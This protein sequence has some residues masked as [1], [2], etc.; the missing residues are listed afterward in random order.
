MFIDS[1][2]LEDELLKNIIGALF[3]CLKMT[4][5]ENEN[6]DKQNEKEEVIIFHLTKI[7]TLTLLNIENIFILFDDYLIPIINSLIEKKI[8]LNFTVNLVCSIIKEILINYKKIESNIKSKDENSTKDNNWWLTQN[9]QKKLFTLLN[10]FTTEHNLI[11]L[12]KNRL[13]V[14][15][16]T[17]IRAMAIISPSEV[18][19]LILKALMSS[20][21]TLW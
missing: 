14:C 2:S 4:L 8:I 15:I 3:E 5:N 17:I 19:T 18:T 7:L 9:W 1:K 16:S 11:E 10:S 21:T 13:F 20:L 6:N 12:T